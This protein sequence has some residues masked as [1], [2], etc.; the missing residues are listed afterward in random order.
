MNAVSVAALS[1][2]G[3]ASMALSYDSVRL[4]S[5]PYF[6]PRAAYAVPLVADLLALG[7]SAQ[8]V[9]TIRE[10]GAGG[11]WWQVTA[12]VAIGLSVAL[13][14]IGTHGWGRLI[15]ALPPLALA[16]IFELCARAF[17]KTWKVEHHADESA[18]PLRLWLTSPLESA[19]TYL[20]QARKVSDPAA[21]AQV[22]EHDAARMLIDH[23]SG[24]RISR[25]RALRVAHRQLRTGAV[26][27]Q[28]VV[29]AAHLRTDGASPALACALA[30]A[31]TA[32]VR[33]QRTTRVS[34]P[35]QR[36]DAPA[37]DASAQST[38]ASTDASAAHALRAV[39][40][41]DA[42]GDA[43]TRDARAREYLLAHPDAS[44]ADLGA[45]LGCSTSQAN[46]IKNRLSAA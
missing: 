25:R 2:V 27:A 5:A 23:A 32:H 22:G 29:R 37:V 16:A 10:R 40:A 15:H 1:V 21:R 19:R 30:L 20:V 31:T 13:N 6:G 28:D 17:A 24:R 7:A 46:R 11:R 38:D 39:D 43:R 45:H 3:V 33:T 18:I 9:R 42:H 44:G 4:A 35:T 12:H 14:V 34:A 36:I 8:Y 41:P 26:S